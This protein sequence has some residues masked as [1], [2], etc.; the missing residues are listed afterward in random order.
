MC[1]RF[2][3]HNPVQTIANRFGLSVLSLGSVSPRYNIAPTDKCLILTSDDQGIVSE[4]MEWGF[5]GTSEKKSNS[6]RIINSRSDKL[7]NIP[8]FLSSL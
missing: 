3:L 2:T 1:G 4:F 7:A 5:V 6:F 8:R